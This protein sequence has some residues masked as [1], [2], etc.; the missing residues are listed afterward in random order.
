MNGINGWALLALGAAMVTC[1]ASFATRNRNDRLSD[2]LAAAAALLIVL[3]FLVG[4][5]P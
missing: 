4:V 1:T 5:K 2:Q 3:M